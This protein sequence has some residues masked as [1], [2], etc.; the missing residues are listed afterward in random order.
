METKFI[1][2]TN[3]PYNWGKF[4]LGRFTP[5]EWAQRSKV[6]KGSM[7][8][9]RGWD[10]KHLLVLDLQTGEG[11]VFRP[12]GSAKADLNKHKIWVCPLYEPFL[13]W[14]Y[15][16]DLTDL[17]ALPDEVTFNLTE[18]PFEM[19]GYRRKGPPVPSDECTCQVSAD[20][21]M[22]HRKDPVCPICGKAK[23]A[24]TD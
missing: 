19:S 24:E 5:E 13:N 2:A 18:A 12:G 1:E 15:K 17:A 23:E 21:Y 14:L 9:G 8:G 10:H 16:Q 7:L 11:T 20:V 6:D 22:K 4:M 3:G